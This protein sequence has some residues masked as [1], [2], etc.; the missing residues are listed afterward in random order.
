MARRNR[1][2][3]CLLELDGEDLRDPCRSN[4]ER[5]NSRLC[6]SARH[7]AWRSRTMLPATGRRSLQKPVPWCL[8]ASSRSGGARLPIGPVAA[9]AQSEEP[10]E[11][12][13]TG[14]GGRRLEPESVLMTAASRGAYG[15]IHC[16]ILMLA[17]R[18]V[19]GRNIFV[20][21]KGTAARRPRLSISDFAPSGS[22]FS[23]TFN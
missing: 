7:S 15:A 14:R 6:S 18:T 5:T 23:R 19:R 12:G 1:Q 4:G 17:D 10:G 21:P 8:R 11:P 16:D 9:L 20:R 2:E 3:T 22:E 13:G